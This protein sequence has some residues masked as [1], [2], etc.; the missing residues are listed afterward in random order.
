ML[1]VFKK[2]R[3]YRHFSDRPVEDDKITEILK[4]AMFSP[5]AHHKRAWEFV[6]VKDK[7]TRAKLANATKY[8]GPANE[9]PAVIVLV[10]Q[11]VDQWVEDLSVVSEAIYLEATNQGLGT[12]WMH[13][14]DMGTPEKPNPEDYVRVTLGI[15]A[16]MRVLCFFPIGYPAEVLP[17]HSENEFEQS[18]IHTEKW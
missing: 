15:P 12:C 8:T 18:K 16:E 6:V 13:L 3:S 2:R 5:S 17:E 7:D 11:N 1:E 9:S 14:K 10:C 4:A